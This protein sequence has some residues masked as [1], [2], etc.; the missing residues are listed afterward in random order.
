MRNNFYQSF[1]FIKW[2]CKA[3]VTG[4]RT[5]HNLWWA[6]QHKV[7]CQFASANVNSED[8]F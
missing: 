2:P 8:D 7:L 5:L 3:G 1:Y 6:A 4:R